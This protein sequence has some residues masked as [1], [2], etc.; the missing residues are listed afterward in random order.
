[1]SPLRR[2]IYLCEQNGVAIGAESNTAMPPAFLMQ[3]MAWREELDEAR[4]A[5]ERLS[6]LASEVARERRDLIGRLRQAIDTD[7]DFPGAAELT[8]QLM[9]V[10]RFNAE[11]HQLSGEAHPGAQAAAEN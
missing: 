10:E 8:R 9:F 1:R 2:A 7:A 11:L 4:R 5:P 6:M 3:Q